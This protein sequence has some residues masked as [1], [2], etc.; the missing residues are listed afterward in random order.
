MMSAKFVWAKI[1][2]VCLSL[3]I[4]SLFV[5]LTGLLG[6]FVALVGLLR[7]VG[8]NLCGPEA[9]NRNKTRKPHM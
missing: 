3:F 7:V 5:M 4:G 9:R 2:L 1:N 6:L 8:P